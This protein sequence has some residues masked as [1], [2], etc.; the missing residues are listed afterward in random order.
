MI[1]IRNQGRRSGSFFDS[2]SATRGSWVTGELG[3]CRTSVC[4]NKRDN[5]RNEPIARAGNRFDVRRLV[6]RVPETS[7]E[8]L[9][10]R[11]DPFVEI[12]ESTW[13]PQFVRPLKEA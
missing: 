12:D 6:R 2:D 3:V 13:F 11:V 8:A 1:A 7:P 9:D 10:G 4:G 5:R